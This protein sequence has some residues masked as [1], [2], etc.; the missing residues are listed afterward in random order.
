MKVEHIEAQSAKELT[1]SLNKFL[2]WVKKEY[3]D[4]P[5]VEIKQSEART[6]HGFIFFER[7]EM[8]EQLDKIHKE[9]TDLREDHRKRANSTRLRSK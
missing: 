6:W 1:N 8:T 9:M 2:E 7:S 5:N 4:E 3:R